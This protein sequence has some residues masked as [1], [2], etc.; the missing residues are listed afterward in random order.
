MESSFAD[1]FNSR[2]LKNSFFFKERG[3]LERFT[4]PVNFFLCSGHETSGI[5]SECR[6][7]GLNFLLF[8]TLN[9]SVGPKGFE[10]G[11]N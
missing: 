4:I 9:R 10:T 7:F 5:G 1:A 8:N 2:L 11:D 6:K 3:S